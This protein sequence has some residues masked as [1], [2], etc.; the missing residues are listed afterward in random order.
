[1]AQ[2]TLEVGRPRVPLKL[3]GAGLLI[4]F[5]VAYLVFTSLRATT[6]Y[7]W[8]VP[9]LFAQP[10]QDGRPVRV[11][12]VVVPGSALQEGTLLRFVM[13]DEGSAEQLTVHYDGVVPDIFQDH[14]QVVVEGQLRADGT[15]QATTL[16]AKCPSR[17]QLAEN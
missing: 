8:T 6:V 12:G 16:L 4:L 14:V 5:G 13:K 17:F 9:E 10:P 11:S 7:Y 15:F 3:I 2:A 1:M